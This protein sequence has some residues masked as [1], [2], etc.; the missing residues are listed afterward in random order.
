M[1]LIVRD[2]LV[3][4]NRTWLRQF[5]CFMSDRRVQLDMASWVYVFHVR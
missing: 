4:I 2:G 5:T 3:L 1:Y